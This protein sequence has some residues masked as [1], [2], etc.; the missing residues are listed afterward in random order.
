MVIMTYYTAAKI[1]GQLLD[2]QLLLQ[3][4]RWSVDCRLEDLEFEMLGCRELS[5]YHRAF[6]EI[7]QRKKSRIADLRATDGSRTMLAREQSQADEVHVQGD[8]H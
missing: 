1:A 8:G 3:E 5:H 4:F 2:C 6:H 7:H